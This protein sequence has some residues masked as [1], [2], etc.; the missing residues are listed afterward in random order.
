MLYVFVLTE[1]GCYVN[2]QNT[3]SN[4]RNTLSKHN[5]APKYKSYKLKI[6]EADGLEN[7]MKHKPL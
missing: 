7:R 2:Q 3:D 4:A 5:T 6:I 1:A